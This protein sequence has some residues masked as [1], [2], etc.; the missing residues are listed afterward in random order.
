[1]PAIETF[2]QDFRYALRTLRKSTGFTTVAVLV[3]A[4]GIGVN[5]AIFSVV[6][7]VML[8][9]LPYPEPD[10]LVSLWE[11]LTREAPAK[12]NT[13][14]RSIGGATTASQPHR[15]TVSPA[16]L[17]DYTRQNHVFSGMAGVAQVGKNL[18]ES[19]PPERIFGEKVTASYFPVLGVQPIRGRAFTGDDDRPG[20]DP[21]VI[22]SHERWQ[23]RF[24]S[25]PNLIGSA[26][27]LDGEKFTVIGVMP[28][29]FRSPGQF[30]FPDKL[31]FYVPAAYPPDLLASH[32]DHEV[33]VIA[34][35][36]PGV[37]I[38][39]AQAELDSISS[40][41][42]QAHPDSNRGIRAVIAPLGEDIVRNVRSSLWV[43]F[44][45]VSLILLIACSN[46]ANLLL[47][48]AVGRQREISI[49][50]ALG[51]TRFRVVREL[52]T[53]SAALTLMGLGVGILFGAWT[54]RLLV[55]LAPAN[56]PRLEDIALN[57]RVVAFTSLLSLATGI[58]FG[59]LP[60]WQVSKARP[61]E[62]LKATSRNLAGASIMRWR[63]VLMMG[64]LAL[65][66]ILL[67]GAG[68]LLK[69]FILL[70]GVDLGFEPERVLAMNIN[71]PETTYSDANRRLAF[72]DQLGEGVSRLPGVQSVAFA[73]RM[74][75]R[76]GWGG[77]LQVE[78][79]T[80]EVTGE[81][82]FQAVNPGYF[83]T[84]GIPLH[85]GRSF[86]PS[87]RAGSAPVAVVNMAFVRRFLSNEDPLG[88]RFRRSRRDPWINIVGIAGD[89]RRGGKAAPL[90]PQVY[91]AA[92]QTALYPVRLADFAVRAPGDP[93]S[94][95]MAIQKQVWAI[96]K[97]QPVTN[98]K[99]LDEVI[100]DSV[101]QRRFQ[102]LLLLLFAGLAMLLA[103]VGVYGVAGYSVS[104][105]TAEIGVRIALGAQRADIL[106]LILR[107]TMLVVAAGIAI[108]A[109]GAYYLSRYM[110]SLLFSV[111]PSDPLTYITLAALL[112][113]TTLTACYIPARRACAIDPTVALRYE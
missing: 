36:A 97:D 34:R 10:R 93:R 16:N 32:G 30:G 95:T 98:V 111:K 17:L 76:G 61:S 72:F 39:R 89:I 56:I 103:L 27:K 55:S 60:A 19:G 13:S 71:L 14:G 54:Q 24:G 112:I 64:E 69:S 108:G 52:V 59:V 50:F 48:R 82:D 73:N 44:G 25:D 57:F 38:R 78:S 102:M 85:Q 26:L 18:T 8:Q 42:Q 23:Q 29:T 96:D 68:L 7:G 104:Q 62:S 86:T 110:A 20:A 91:L 31:Q 81:A 79:P 49:R 77:G 70:R 58:L 33:G 3:L 113:G 35:L 37:S 11:D 106:A 109:A 90:N 1:M 94:L 66:M 40:Q 51:A 63:A 88:R 65:S 21:V 80:G 83:Q 12:W 101:A 9:P 75:M 43:L 45:A 6:E 41:L 105:R 28:P 46:V 84:L 74:P 100:S 4:L 2:L 47:V 107:Q 67:T 15:M 87:D 99:T 5:S 53:Q 22:L 92:A